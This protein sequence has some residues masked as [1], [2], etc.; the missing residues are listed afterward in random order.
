ALRKRAIARFDPGETTDRL[1]R[2]YEDL[3]PGAR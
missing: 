3:R 1:L 2:V